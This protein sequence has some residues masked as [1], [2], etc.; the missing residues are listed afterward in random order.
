MKLPRT[1]YALRHDATGKM[2]IGSTANPRQRLL[3]H[4]NRLKNGTHNSKQLQA[5][6]DRHADKSLTLILLDEIKTFDERGK[7]YEWMEVY[8]TF[9][10]T[11]G[12][13]YADPKLPESPSHIRRRA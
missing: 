4:I 7:E 1:V 3:K 5:D 9:D 2:Y 11:N 13:N 6:Y 8:N 12:Y 10:A